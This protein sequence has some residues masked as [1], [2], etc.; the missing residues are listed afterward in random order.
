MNISIGQKFS[1]PRIASSELSRVGQSYR[2]TIS[3]ILLGK[4]A[5]SLRIIG[6]IQEKISPSFNLPT[7][8]LE[9]REGKG[10]KND[11]VI[12]HNKHRFQM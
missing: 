7:P 12:F 6:L 10:K 8:G 11:Q 3:N 5:F 1:S 9:E 4:S 2:A